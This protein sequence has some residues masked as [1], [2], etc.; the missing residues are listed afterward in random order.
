MNKS[1][2]VF[3]LFVLP[4]SAPWLLQ[5]P[6]TFSPIRATITSGSTLRA[7]GSTRSSTPLQSQSTFQEAA[8]LILTLQ[9]KITCDSS[10]SL[11]PSLLVNRADIPLA[12]P[13]PALESGSW[14]ARSPS[15]HLWPPP[16][17]TPGCLA[18]RG[19]PGRGPARR[20]EPR[21]RGSL[22]P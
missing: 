11:L 20:P 6:V 15:A 7:A 1:C 10:S 9:I 8:T 19:A 17:S 21:P 3:K 16:G 4:S 12:P 22:S 5:G 13:P 2:P 14:R 18:C